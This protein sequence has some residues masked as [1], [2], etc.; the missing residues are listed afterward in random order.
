MKLFSGEDQK[1]MGPFKRG[2]SL[3][4]SSPYDW[5]KSVS[6]DNRASST[7]EVQKMFSNV[8]DIEEHLN[9]SSSDPILNPDTATKVLQNKLEEVQKVFTI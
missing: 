3:R 2:G 9:N 7:A 4:L 1:D 8:R 5:S 6:G